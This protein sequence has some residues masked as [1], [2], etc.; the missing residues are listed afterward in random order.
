MKRSL[1]AS[2]MIAALLA[3]AVPA[4]ATSTSSGAAQLKFISGAT[5]TMSI[6][7]QYSAAGAQGNAAPTL[8]PSIAGVCTAPAS[9]TNF[10]LSFGALT[11][12]SNAATACLYKNAVAVAVTS[13][14]ANGFVVNEYLDATPTS[15]IGICAFP[16]GGATFP[17][18]P[19]AA[20]VAV[21]ARS[22]NPAAGTFTGN[23]LTSCAAGGSIVPPGTGGLSSAGANPGNVGAPGLEFYSPS[24]TQLAFMTLAT[25][26]SVAGPGVGNYYAAEDIQVNMATG[27]GSTTVGQTGVYMTIQLVPN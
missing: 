14:D 6:V 22:G 17:L 21:S 12:R 4:R 26:T 2:V 19:A 1:A 15:G 11:P 3:P 9:E 24:G 8:L 7:T 5:L 16:N 13:N 27:A 18:T 23:N 10:T 20:P 25:P